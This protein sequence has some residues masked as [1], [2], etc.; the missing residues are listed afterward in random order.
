M[1]KYLKTTIIF[2]GVWFLASIINGLLCGICVALLEKEFSGG[3]IAVLFLSVVFS[4]ACSVPAVGMVW[5]TTLIGQATGKRGHELFQL[6]LGTALIC[7]IAGGL[8]FIYTLGTEFMHAR[9]LLGLCVIISAM[10]SLLF[11]RKQ[12]KTNA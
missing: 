12:I 6:V 10:A 8:I 4:F 9:F 3:G 1:S 11:F 5:L 2:F 7:S